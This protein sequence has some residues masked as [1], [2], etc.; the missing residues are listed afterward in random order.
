MATKRASL[1]EPGSSRNITAT[2][3]RNFLVRGG[4]LAP[5]Y[6]ISN[7]ARKNSVARIYIYSPRGFTLPLWGN[8]RYHRNLVRYHCEIVTRVSHSLSL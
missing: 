4:T 7:R 8:V 3:L 1:G 6:A 5:E 2:I